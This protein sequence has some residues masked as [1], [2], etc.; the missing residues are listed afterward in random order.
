MA[1]WDRT[2]VEISTKGSIL[3]V[4]VDLS[5][6]HGITEK[7]NKRI[8]RAYYCKIPGKENILMDLSVW[9]EV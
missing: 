6:K 9:V 2:N 4:K 8:A 5:E 1:Y 3:T 7:G